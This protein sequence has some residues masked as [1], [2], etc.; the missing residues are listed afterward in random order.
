MIEMTTD[1]PTAPAHLLGNLANADAFCMRAHY[2]FI[3]L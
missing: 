3:A 1:G 2:F